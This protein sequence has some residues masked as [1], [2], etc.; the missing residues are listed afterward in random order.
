MC[1]CEVKILSYH[2]YTIFSKTNHFFNLNLFID[3][4]LSGKLLQNLILVT[5]EAVDFRKNAFFGCEHLFVF[6]TFFF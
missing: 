3:R 6:L 5:L 1:I 4:A 2:I